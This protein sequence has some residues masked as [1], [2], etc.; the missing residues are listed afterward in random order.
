MNKQCYRV[1]FNKARGMFMVVS[2]ITKSQNKTA[3]N[4]SSKK[5]TAKSESQSGT[6]LS[7]SRL[8]VAI[9]C[10]QSMIYTQVQAANSQIQNTASNIP[11]AQ[12]AA[13]LKATNGTPIVNIRTPNSK[14][15]SHNTYNQFD[16]GSNGAILNNSID[17]ANTQ[18]AGAITGNQ[19]LAKNAANTILNEVRSNAPAKFQGNLEIAGQRA[20]VIIASPSGLQIQ[21]GGFINANQA[22]LTTGTPKI[23]STGNLTGFDVKQGQIQFDNAATGNALGGDLYDGKN[24]NQANYVDVLARAVTINGQIHANQDVNIVSG[25][26][27]VDYDTGAATKITGIGIA[28]TLAVD[29]STLG[30]I[31]AGSINLVGTENGLGVRNAGNINAAQQIVL[32]NSGKIENTG[33]IKTTKAQ[34]SLVSINATGNAG[35][36]DH[37]GTISSYGMIDMQADKDITLD[38]GIVKKNSAGTA[39]QLMPDIIRIDAGGSLKVSNIS[40]IRNKNV[41]DQTNIYM[42]STLDTVV[43]SKS[44]IASNGGVSIDA[45]RYVHLLDT[46]STSAGVAALNISSKSGTTVDNATIAGSGDVYINSRTADTTISNNSQLSA[47]KSLT[48]GAGRDATLKTGSR[49]IGANDLT[50]AATRNA[51]VDTAGSIKVTN[52]AVVQGEELGYLKNN[53]Q[54]FNVGKQLTVKGKQATVLDSTANATNGI[55]ITSQGKVTTITNSNLNSANGAVTAVANQAALNINKL[56]TNANSTILA[57]GNNIGITA[58]NLKADNIVIESGATTSINGLTTVAKDA[59]QIGGTS[60][61]SKANTSVINSTLNSTGNTV[62]R[63]DKSLTLTNNDI[64]SQGIVLKTNTASTLKNTAGINNTFGDGDITLTKNTL[65][66]NGTSDTSNGIIV[67]AANHL[68]VIDS[69][70][71]S[72]GSTSLKSGNLMRVNNSTVDADKHLN[73]NSSN[74]L[75]SNG[76][77]TVNSNTALTHTAGNTTLKAGQIVSIDSNAAQSY[78]NTDITG[79][80]ILID[81]ANSLVFNT[82][83][84]INATGNTKL[85]TSKEKSIDGKAINTLNGDLAI[86]SGVGSITIDPKNITLNAT[87]DMSLTA[88]GGKLHLKGYAGTKGLGSEQVVKLTVD[89]DISLSGKDVLIEGSD[90]VSKKGFSA[91]NVVLVDG[92]SVPT[93][94]ISVTA[95][96]GS[97]ELIGIKNS[98]SNYISPYKINSINTEIEKAK[99]DLNQSF[100]NTKW[101]ENYNLQTRG[102]MRHV[103]LQC[104]D[105][106]MIGG[107]ESH[108]MSVL[109]KDK[110]FIKEYSFEYFRI[111]ESAIYKDYVDYLAQKNDLRSV[112]ADLN[113]VLETSKKTSTGFEHKT[114]SLTGSKDINITAKQGVL[115]EGGDITSS[116]GGITITAEGNLAPVEVKDDNDKTIGINYDSIRI[117][118]LADIY[119]QG[120]IDKEGKVAGSNYSYHQLINQPKLNAN[121]DIKILAQ[122]GRPLNPA[123]IVFTDN[124]AVNINSADIQSTNGDVRIDAAR[125]NINLEASQVAFMDGSQTTSTSR[126]WYGKKKTKTTT[127]TSFNSNAVTTDI[128]AK[129]IILNAESDIAVYGSEL[130]AGT[131]GDITLTAG[132]KIKLYAIK[133]VDEKEV[134]IKKQS[135]FLGVRYNKNHTNDTRQEITQLPTDLV[136]SKLN[137]QSGGDTLLQGTIV[138]TANPAKIRV[139]IGKYAEADAKVILDVITNQITT[140]HNQEKE[141]TVWQKTVDKGSVVTTASLPKF[142]QTPTMTDANGKPVEVSIEVPVSVNNATKSSIQAGT[143]ELGKIALNLSKQPG[144]EYLAALDKTND[145]NWVQVDLI[146][147]NWNYT[148]EGLTPAAAALIAIAVA[149]A[150]HGMDGGGVATSLLGQTSGAAASGSAAAIPSTV[151]AAG[152]AG[153]AAFASLASQ[154]ATSLINNKGD[155][156]KTLKQLSS[157]ATI[158]SMATAALTAGL[159]AKLQIPN[160]TSNEFANK[161]VQSVGEGMSSAFVDAAIN[162]TNLEEA[163]KNSLRSALVDVFAASTFTNMVKPIDADDFASNLAH[164]LV[165][166][167]VGCVTANAKQQSCDAGALGAAVGEMLGDYLVDDPSKLTAKQKTDILDAA[168]LLA[169]SVAL[170]TNVDVNTAA[171]SAE[172]AVEN[173]ALHVVRSKDGTGRDLAYEIFNKKIAQCKSSGN[174]CTHLLQQYWAENENNY[175]EL[176]QKCGKGGLVCPTY[177]EI[178]AAKYQSVQKLSDPDAKKIATLML[179]RD[180]VLLDNGIDTA[181]R[182]YQ[183]G[184]DP[185]L[186]AGL[187]IGKGSSSV[188]IKGMTR[189]QAIQ[190]FKNAG[191]GM[192]T[193]MTSEAAIEYYL[194]GD[195]NLRDVMAIGF[196]TGFFGA[197]LTPSIYTPVRYNKDGALK[198]SIDKPLNQKSV[199]RL[200]VNDVAVGTPQPGE[201]KSAAALETKIG[202]MRRAGKVDGPVDFVVVYGPNKGKTVDFLFTPNTKLNESKFNQFFDNNWST[203]KGKIDE[204]LAKSDI[205]PMDMRSIKSLQHRKQIENYVKTKPLI[206]QSKVI[207]MY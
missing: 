113:Q 94:G 46:S 96:N 50:I 59:K 34:T 77:R 164:K 106:G 61:S 117:T 27:T 91:S 49:I 202:T 55:Y 136:A 122:G 65:S 84:S 104:E 152:L 58:S 17:V 16:I 166:A 1:V 37:S 40:D 36:I 206:Q 7:Y 105:G 189:Q 21:G 68:N 25:S 116:A 185:L 78:Q 73:I 132:R 135:S 90:L 196:T 80:A 30:G 97:V 154:V 42:H 63:S 200:N 187:V 56:N 150:L 12:R 161:L 140:T 179:A 11:E 38:A 98:F 160:M 66:T 145:I 120:D 137:T 134:D 111:L 186:L 48:I 203:T 35:S 54:G 159:A 92:K 87:S 129:N 184:T 69:Q 165:A 64:Q 74:Q 171:N 13:L 5:S 62:M 19:Y 112:I 102:F 52:D 142:N 199:D 143:E 110:S 108:C 133:N 197:A 148:Q 177:E 123:L 60:I 47:K 103:K 88:R 3:G 130:N 195:I 201:A 89:G 125:G 93:A 204:H 131:T 53:S 41:D 178:I 51:T 44:A 4:G 192:G 29:V 175:N 81:S 191:I 8:A 82:N 172:I 151:T 118:G 20:D 180:L 31:Y 6:K 158:R 193:G 115:I 168:K 205:V 14:G 138:N 128:V 101:E 194:T 157:S 181:D 22:T 119:Q 95:T 139:G 207:Y 33:D 2:E 170:L 85:A 126:K 9:L 45:D 24:K 57:A 176:K 79:G 72:T 127:T 173:N 70:T 99:I 188:A 146:Q 182:V 76:A 124:N 183:I 43:D 109:Q 114:G 167:G 23:D 75:V 174:D 26:N 156:S 86:G 141:S 169:G 149:V 39:V 83:T 162:K 71:K 147:K 15:L 155:I 18:L 121:K 32:T 198:V 28:P 107:G 67:D 190:V 144:Y 100:Y 153:N 163:L 10:C